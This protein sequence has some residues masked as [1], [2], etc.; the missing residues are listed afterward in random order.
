MNIFKKS[1]GFTRE[2]FSTAT[3]CK[4]ILHKKQEKIK[5]TLDSM[6]KEAKIN[7]ISGLK[8]L[9]IAKYYMFEMAKENIRKRPK[10]IEET[11]NSNNNN[12]NNNEP[13]NK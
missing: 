3:N 11:N 6:S 4:K 9:E 7:N 10:L 8:D 12:I 1:F 2:L 13:S 5:K